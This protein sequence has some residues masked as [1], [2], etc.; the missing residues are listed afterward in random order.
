MNKLSDMWWYKYNPINFDALILNEDIKPTLKEALEV[1]PNLLLFGPPG[2]GKSAFAR[3]LLE[4][5]GYDHLWINASKDRGIDV[6]R[7]LIVPFG[8]GY[9]LHPLKI[10]VI[11]EA[12]QLTPD[13]QKSLKEETENIVDLTR[14]IFI[15]NEVHKIRSEIVSRLWTVEF[16]KPPVKEIWERLNMILDNEKVEIEKQLLKDVIKECYPDIR[17]MINALHMSTSRGKIKK[18]V[19]NI[20]EELLSDILA[21]I[22][23]K[24][25]DKI[26]QLLRSNTINYSELYKYLFDNVGQF[27]SP[28]DA[29]LSI[30]E[31]HRWDAMVSIR[32]INFMYMVFKMISEGAV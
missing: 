13:A 30:G 5:T 17:K 23:K 11:N 31:A 28:G 9:S 19:Y 25:V 2:V 22:L 21:G 8:T 12:D 20:G 15:T 32:E 7:E 10:I 18:V 1:V 14:F 26:R 16:N 4:H 27:R 29:V 6:V 3:I 24:D